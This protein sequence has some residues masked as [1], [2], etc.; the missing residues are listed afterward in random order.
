MIVNQ[1]V[2]LG[3]WIATSKSFQRR[4]G[5]QTVPDRTEFHNENAFDFGHP[6]T[7]YTGDRLRR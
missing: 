3:V 5:M 6:G 2:D 1:P 7:L 4:G